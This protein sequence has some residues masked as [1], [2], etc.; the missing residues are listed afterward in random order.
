[1]G[2]AFHAANPVLRVELSVV[3]FPGPCFGIRCSCSEKL[4]NQEIYFRRGVRLHASKSARGT[5]DS[6]MVRS[7]C[8][9]RLC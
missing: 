8:N 5:L 2:R 3:F 1:M 4:R 9:P 6:R 7:I